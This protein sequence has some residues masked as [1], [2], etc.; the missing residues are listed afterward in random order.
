M[1]KNIVIVTNE[2]GILD[3]IFNPLYIQY[4]DKI[5]KV[6]NVPVAA[7][8]KAFSKWIEIVNGEEIIMGCLKQNE[9]PEYIVY[10]VPF[11]G[12]AYMVAYSRKYEL[13]DLNMVVSVKELHATQAYKNELYHLFMNSRIKV[14][15][16]IFKDYFNMATINSFRGEMFDPIIEMIENDEIVQGA[17]DLKDLLA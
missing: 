6:N 2:E 4:P 9:G 12:L 10:R 5:M 13:D 3:R 16:N 7:N 1:S 15:L 17:P 11:A 14:S 8:S